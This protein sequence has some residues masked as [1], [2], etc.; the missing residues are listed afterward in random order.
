MGLLTLTGLVQ[1]WH[2]Y[3]FALLLG[4][5][6]AFDAPARQTFVSELVTEI[7]LQ[8]AVALNSTSFNAARMIGPAVAGTLIAAV[9]TGWVFVINAASYVAVI[10]AMKMLRVHELYLRQRAVRT[11]GSFLEGFRYVWRR[12]T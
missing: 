1:L 3:V 10:G 11:R 5:V 2:V 6:A 12:P 7:D 9:G 4:C 8:N